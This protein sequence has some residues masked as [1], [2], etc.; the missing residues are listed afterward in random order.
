MREIMIFPRLVQLAKHCSR[1]VVGILPFG[2]ISVRTFFVV[3]VIGALGAL[4]VIKSVDTPTSNDLLKDQDRAQWLARTYA[5]QIADSDIEALRDKALI[6]S[7]AAEELISSPPPDWRGI[8]RSLD[9][10]TKYGPFGLRLMSPFWSR[11]S[12]PDSRMQLLRLR[13]QGDFL[14]LTF[15]ALDGNAS[16]QFVRIDGRPL[17]VSVAIR[18]FVPIPTDRFGQWLRRL[19]NVS[20]LPDFIRR[21]ASGDWY[22]ID[23]RYSFNLREYYDWVQQNAQR[24]YAENENVLQEEASRRSKLTGK[25]REEWFREWANRIKNDAQRRLD[26]SYQWASDECEAQWNELMREGD[27]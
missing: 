10:E 2:G 21:R 16:S 15:A 27:G 13:R 1:A 18:Y 4:L 14:V 12:P 19:V 17:L 25:E 9:V 26:A 7:G 3:C 5:N 23:Y 24:L 22:L 11:F 8:S 6:G 20:F